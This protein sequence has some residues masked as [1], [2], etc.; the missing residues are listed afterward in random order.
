MTP[1]A[2]ETL[3]AVHCLPH[4]LLNALGIN[5][6]GRL[7]KTDPCVPP[8]D[9]EYRHGYVLS[10]QGKAMVLALTRLPHPVKQEVWT[11][12]YDDSFDLTARA[13]QAL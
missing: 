10:Q 12:S 3:L 5:Q 9:G 8:D 4:R 1:L 11:V 13:G 7:I 6:C 2:I